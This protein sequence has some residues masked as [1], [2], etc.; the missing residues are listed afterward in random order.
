MV[1]GA[2]PYLGGYQLTVIRPLF[3]ANLT[4]SGACTS[5][6]YLSAPHPRK[7]VQKNLLLFLILS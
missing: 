1:G 2:V 5:L 7:G 6:S 4:I 3:Y